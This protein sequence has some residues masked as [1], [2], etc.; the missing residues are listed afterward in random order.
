MLHNLIR[1]KYPC[2]K[3]QGRRRNAK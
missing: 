1:Q 3:Y 2:T